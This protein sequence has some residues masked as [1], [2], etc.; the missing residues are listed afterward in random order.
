MHFI[1]YQKAQIN[2]IQSN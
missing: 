1:Q 2:A